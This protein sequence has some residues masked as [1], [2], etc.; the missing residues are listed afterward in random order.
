MTYLWNWDNIWQIS[1]LW[2]VVINVRNGH[3]Q[4]NSFPFTSWQDG[5]NHLGNRKE[6]ITLG[7]LFF[8]IRSWRK[9]RHVCGLIFPFQVIFQP[10]KLCPYMSFMKVCTMGGHFQAFHNGWKSLRNLHYRVSQ[11]VLNQGKFQIREIREIRILKFFV[12]K[13]RQIEGTS[14]VLS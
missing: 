14:V 10:R 4:W 13:T 7:G 5:T 2:C 12:K 11:Q 8:S 3:N 1:E 6:F 9:R